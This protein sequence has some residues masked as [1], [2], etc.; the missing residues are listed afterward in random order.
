M[1]SY[2]LSISVRL[3]LKHYWA[4]TQ[5]HIWHHRETTH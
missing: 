1:D 3:F 2:R 5:H 4:D